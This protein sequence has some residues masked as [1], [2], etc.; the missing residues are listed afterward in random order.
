MKEMF[1]ETKIKPVESKQI[2]FSIRYKLL[3]IVSFI[4]ILGLSTMI[5]LVTLFYKK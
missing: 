1:T 2:Q 5:Y 3:L 4:I